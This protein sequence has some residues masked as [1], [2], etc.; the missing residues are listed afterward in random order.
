MGHWGLDEG[1]STVYTYDEKDFKKISGLQVLAG[2][3]HST[4]CY[5]PLYHSSAIY[6]FIDDSRVY[7]STL[8]LLQLSNSYSQK[9]LVFLI[10]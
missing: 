6:N 1:L 8:K 3:K 2:H 4:D 9:Q 7:P 10:S 5:S